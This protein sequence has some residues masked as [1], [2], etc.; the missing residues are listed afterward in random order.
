MQLTALVVGLW[1]AF[2]GRW[3]KESVGF[4]L[5]A[6]LLAAALTATFTRASWA[7]LLLAALV[8]LWLRVGW[9]ARLATA[10]LALVALLGMN[11]VLTAK[12]GVGF[13]N[14][15]DL[16]MQYRRLMWEDGLRLVREHPLLGIG[17]DTVKVRW[18][19]LGIRAYESMGLRSHFHSTP[20]QLAVERG[21]LGL[22]AWLWLMA[23]YALMLL[24]RLLRPPPAGDWWTQ[25]LRLGI[26]GATLGFLASGLL[27]YNF[28]DS[29]V[30][31]LFWLLMGITL[32]LERFAGSEEAEHAARA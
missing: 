6:L 12:R 28:G 5:A 2:P 14:P 22:G 31:M 24:R 16:S 13:Y 29:E 8:M 7:A 3:R 15:N 4:V 23:A 9:R 20:I 19:E 21:L 18:K 1:L 26:L 27:H 17:M 32:W 10:A 11:Q 25:G 30:V